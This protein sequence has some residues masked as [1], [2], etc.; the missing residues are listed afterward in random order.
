[1]SQRVC[2]R[3]RRVIQSHYKKAISKQLKRIKTYTTMKN[4]FFPDS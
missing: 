4:I 1:M 3:F 2:P